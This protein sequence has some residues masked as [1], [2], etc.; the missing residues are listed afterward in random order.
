MLFRSRGPQPSGGSGVKQGS[1]YGGSKQKDKPEHDEDK[2]K[3]EE[4]EQIDELSKST[5]G[6]Y[7]KKASY[8]ATIKRT[9]ASDFEHI[10]DKARKTSSKAASKELADKYKAKSW[11][12]KKGI[13]KAVDR[14]TKEETQYP[15]LEKEDKPGKVKTAA[16][17]PHP[18]GVNIDT[19]EGWKDESKPV[20]AEENN[21]KTYSQF[22]EQLLEYTPG[23]GGVTRVQIGR[24]HV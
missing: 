24:A 5:L 20:K 16:E 15:G 6:S 10:A 4:V 2:V 21:M 19:V 22:I 14:L 9:I 8:D 18:K 1:R 17:S 13:G 12:R 7:A 11:Q 23:P 3:K